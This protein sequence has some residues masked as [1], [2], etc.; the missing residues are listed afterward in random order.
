MK[1]VIR[2]DPKQWH[3]CRQLEEEGDTGITNTRPLP[4][5]CSRTPPPDINQSPFLCLLCPVERKS[6]DDG[7]L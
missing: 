3:I 5:S 7:M 4:V 2:F 1:D 6:R